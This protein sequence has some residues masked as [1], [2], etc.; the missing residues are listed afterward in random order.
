MCYCVLIARLLSYYYA[1]IVWL[2]YYYYV[3]IVLSLWYFLYANVNDTSSASINVTA[4][5]VVM[6]FSTFFFITKIYQ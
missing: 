6:V 4:N 3:I 1:I 5:L 2:L